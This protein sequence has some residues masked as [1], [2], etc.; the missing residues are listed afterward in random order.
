MGHVHVEAQVSAR[1]RKKVRFLVDTGATYTIIP[2]ELVEDLGIEPLP[3][4]FRVS[5]VDGRIKRLKACALGIEV[6]GRSG[7][8]TALILRGSEPLLGVETL[9]ALGLKVNTEKGRLEP[10]RAKGALL[11]GLRLRS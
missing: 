8:T 6:A 1:R 2:E 5:L 11:V 7:P 10:T 3:Q 9:E 4:R